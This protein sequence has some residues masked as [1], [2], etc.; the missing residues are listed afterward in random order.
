[1]EQDIGFDSTGSLDVDALLNFCGVPKR[2]L[3][4]VAG[5][6]A[7]FSLR[8]LRTA[9]TGPAI[10]VRRST[11]NV[12]ADIGFNTDGSLNTTELLA[13]VGSANGFITT[14]Y[15][16]T[17][18][19]KHALQVIPASQPRIVSAGVIE[20]VGGK[21]SIRFVNTYLLSM[22]TA[23]GITGASF[24]AVFSRLGLVG[25]NQMFD[26]RNTA[27]QTPLLDDG[28]T[29]GF[30]FRMRNDAS[31]LVTTPS[32]GGDTNPH[33][34]SA[35]W[36]QTTLNARLDGGVSQTANISGAL[37]LDQLGIGCNGRT[38]GQNFF[39]GLLSEFIVFPSA[40]SAF[41]RV[42][43][44]A[45]QAMYH[46]ITYAG[47]LPSGF[48]TTWYDQSGTFA[49][50]L[51]PNSAC[52]GAAIGVPGTQ[53][54]GW[55]FGNANGLSWQIVGT[56]TEDGY[57]YVDVR[58]VGTSTATGGIFS[59]FSPGIAATPGTAYSAAAGFK[60]VAGS[61]N[62]ISPLTLRIGSGGTGQAIIAPTGLLT[63]AIIQ[64]Q[65]VGDTNGPLTMRFNANFVGVAVDFTLRIAAPQL[66]IGSTLATYTRT[67]GTAAT[68]NGRDAVQA[69]AANQPEIITNG[70][71]NLVNSRP[72][73]FVDGLLKRLTTAHNLL[74]Y[75]QAYMS[76]VGKRIGNRS[77]A[78]SS[79]YCGTGL[80]GS[81][82]TR[83]ALVSSTI[84]TRM[85]SRVQVGAPTV[86]AVGP[87][88]GEG[89]IAAGRVLPN[90]TAIAY[91]NG[92]ASAPLAVTLAPLVTDI[93][94]ALGNGQNSRSLWGTGAETIL[95]DT[96]LT[97]A[98]HSML[99]ADQGAYYGIAIS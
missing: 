33:T 45:S 8:S 52:V 25:Q 7:A 93:F 22:V 19:N 76:F 73:M 16:Q 36:N 60:L 29:S 46:G 42:S 51:I 57:D 71:L 99:T 14:W 41:G 4:S 86:T 55:S 89:C 39:W 47:T 97:D 87:A 15:D 66:N 81:T 44:E 50:N 91:A 94:H 70:V 54:T 31:Q 32:L 28:G 65:N 11:D 2:P 9:Y 58:W 30:S 35:V 34:Y 20:T 17:G 85:D 84:D 18:N 6:A 88:L 64:N 38:P 10:R 56:G 67:T 12:E 40:L 98:Q 62:D 90:A 77:P 5:A 23:T 96:A 59:S 24:A 1:M 63:R 80:V 37:T 48:V 74:G 21:P 82:G 69:T 68:G 26:W 83:L 49:Q 78:V 61:L 95:F 75:T 92:L 53:P 43:L 3:D 79:F 72:A 27:T 13:F